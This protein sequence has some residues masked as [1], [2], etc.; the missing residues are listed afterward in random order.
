MTTDS[1]MP[2]STLTLTPLLGSDPSITVVAAADAGVV[3]PA[4]QA[5][6]SSRE[7][8][9]LISRAAGGDSKAFEQ[10]YRRHLDR[11]YGLCFRLCGGDIPRAEQAT[12]DAFVRAWERLESFRGDSLFSTWM[13]RVT[14]NVVLGEHRLLKRWVAF[15]DDSGDE[16]L[17]GEHSGYL[18]DRARHEDL[19]TRVDLERAL[20]R[21]PKGARAVLILH[22]I[23]GYPHEEISALTGIAVG[24]SKAQLH[25]A[26]KLLRE[27]LQ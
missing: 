7:E 11:V 18:A 6:A 1:L 27:W 4:A 24:T 20:A 25:R 16:G 17:D 14:V 8:H 2:V 22:D 9:A 12:Q 19:G 15:E 10:L 26:R 5:Q 21:L 3:A 23:E 13:H